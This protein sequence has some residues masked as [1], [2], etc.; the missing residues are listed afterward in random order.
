MVNPGDSTATAKP[1]K[2]LIGKVERGRGHSGLHRREETSRLNT[3]RKCFK[4]Y[5]TY[6]TSKTIS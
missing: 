1:Q 5:T 3:R 2:L 4:D 6:L